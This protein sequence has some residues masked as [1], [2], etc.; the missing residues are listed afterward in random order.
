MVFAAGQSRSVEGLMCAYMIQHRPRIYAQALQKFNRNAEWL[1]TVRIVS[2]PRVLEYVLPYDCTVPPLCLPKSRAADERRSR[3]RRDAARRAI[4]RVSQ[5][6]YVAA[7]T[8][9]GNRRSFR[10]FAGHPRKGRGCVEAADC[11]C[12]RHRFCGSQRVTSDAGEQSQTPQFVLPQ[13]RIG[14]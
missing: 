9:Y 8:W 13:R 2:L 7:L 3:I 6:H 11:G 4:T 14:D 5:R 1:R 10:Q 12:E